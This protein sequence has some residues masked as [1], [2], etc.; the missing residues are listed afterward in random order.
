MLRGCVILSSE[1]GV[2]LFYTIGTNAMTE[3][4]F[5]V[6]CDIRFQ[7]IPVATIIA[8]FFARGANRDEAAQGLDVRERGLQ[9]GDELLALYF[10]A[11]ALRQFMLCGFI[12]A[13]VVQRNGSQLREASH[14]GDVLLIKTRAL[15]QM[16]CAQHADARPM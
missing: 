5:C 6:P 12:Q 3:V 1:F 11:F 7:L 13:R 15:G 14:G 2:E 8:D 4:G 10:S 16:G 9:V